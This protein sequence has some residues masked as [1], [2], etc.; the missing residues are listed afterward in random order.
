MTDKLLKITFA[1]D[2][3][4]SALQNKACKMNNGIYNYDEVFLPISSFLHESDYVCGNLETPIGGDNSVFTD[5]PALFN[6]PQAFLTALKECGFD[7]LSTANNHAMDRG[8]QGILDTLHFLDKH[9]FDHS[10]TYQTKEESSKTFIKDFNGLK[11]AFLSFTYG[12]NS[13][14]HGQLLPSDK[15]FMIDFL[16]AQP[17]ELRYKTTPTT[18]KQ[19]IKKGIRLIIPVKLKAIIR[20]VLGK[21][22]IQGDLDNVLSSE[23][24]N[25]QNKIYIERT[26]RKIQQ[27]H[28]QADI[29]VCSLHCGGQYN[30]QIGE[31]THYIHNILKQAGVDII[32]GN[33][34]H[35][36]LPYQRT[37]TC[38]STFS[39]GNFTFTPFDGWYIDG[40]LADYSILLH[41]YFDTSNKKIVKYSFSVVKNV[42]STNGLTR[43]FLVYDLI[44]NE[45][46]SSKR[47]KLCKENCAAIKRFT[48][49]AI[50]EIK[51]EYEIC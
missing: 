38:F 35:C 25:P 39:L 32:V 15:E 7:Y 20:S 26:Q 14:F 42:R 47:N 29:V 27:A 49:K 6:T 8:E 1:G 45:K 3:M 43:T 17:K 34:P 28:T 24:S 22:S 12:A 10:G 16:K 21:R 31:Y 37:E 2:I 41:I 19:N 40:V 4:S 23:I 11:I 13:E 5:A 9:N 50:H 36:I 51:K 30:N 46:D 48:G 33:H 18:L 44:S